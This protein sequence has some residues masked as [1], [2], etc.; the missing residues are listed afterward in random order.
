MKSTAPFLVLL[1]VLSPALAATNC[2]V[3]GYDVGKYNAFLTNSTATTPAAC[4]AFC[5]T[6]TA[7]KCAS[8][9]VGPICLLYNVT[10]NGNVNAIP[11]S[12]YTFYDAACVV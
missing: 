10:V 2:T 7:P 8:F 1:A 12:P 6:S 5:A 9:A 4:K 3:V 11:T